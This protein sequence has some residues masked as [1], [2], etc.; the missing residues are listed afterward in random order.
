MRETK[1]HFDNSLPGR[2][3]ASPSRGERRT[4]RTAYGASLARGDSRPRR[5]AVALLFARHILISF[6]PGPAP[7][8]ARAGSPGPAART[9]GSREASAKAVR[10][11]HLRPSSRM[12]ANTIC[13]RPTTSPATSPGGRQKSVKL[14]LIRWRPGPPLPSS[15]GPTA[16]G[17][18]FL[19]AALPAA[20]W[21]LGLLAS[22]RS[23][24]RCCSTGP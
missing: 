19:P 14:A 7:L 10:S 24:A 18:Y 3:A 5:R 23:P 2:V 11:S 9:A 4:R 20:L 17:T 12:P 21:A 16:A 15:R 13:I 1:H 8:P 22:S 6:P